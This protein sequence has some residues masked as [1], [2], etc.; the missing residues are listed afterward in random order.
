MA[1]NDP[2]DVLKDAHALAASMQPVQR[3]A[4]DY[5]RR[6]NLFSGA[7]AF[8]ASPHGRQ[9]VVGTKLA[10]I[11]SEAAE[12]LEEVRRESTD[13]SDRPRPPGDPLS[14]ELADIVIRTME[15]A[16]DLGIDL[17]AAIAHKVGQTVGGHRH[18]GLHF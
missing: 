7:E 11:Q 5:A 16:E 10:L 3:A 4:H 1:T 9:Y 18:G 17:G 15:L 12:A 14:A 13:L 6:I 8:S 2:R